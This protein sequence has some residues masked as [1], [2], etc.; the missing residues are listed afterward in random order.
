MSHSPGIMNLP[1]ASITRAS[2]G[3]GTRPALSTAA[4]RPP[5]ITT[6]R[7]GRA[8]APVASITVT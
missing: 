8:G 3:S 5:R 2:R 1:V 7:S 6:S 4:M